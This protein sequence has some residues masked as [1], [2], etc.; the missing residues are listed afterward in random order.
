MF[1]SW[2]PNL[3]RVPLLRTAPKGVGTTRYKY[4]A[5]NGVKRALRDFGLVQPG[6]EASSSLI[7]V[8]PPPAS[9]LN[10]SVARQKRTLQWCHGARPCARG[11]GVRAPAE[12]LTPAAAPVPQ[13]QPMSR[14]VS[15]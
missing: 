3:L 12:C 1:S 10:G 9:M 11:A 2:V 15:Q 8:L 5:P 4:L 6:T 7:T 14:S 13:R